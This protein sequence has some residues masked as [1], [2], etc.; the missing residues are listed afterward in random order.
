[1]KLYYS[2]TPNP[3]KPCAVAKHVNAPVEFVRVE[4]AKGEHKTPAYLAVNPNGKTPAL[5]DGDVH[6]WEAHA[7]M[8]YLALKSGSDL[9]PD[10]PV[11]QIEVMKWLN[12]DTAHFSRHAGRLWFQRFLK[13][14]IG[15]GDP[16]AAEI[17]EATGFFKQFAGILD[18]HLKGRDHI[19]GNRLTIAD[20]GV[21]TFIPLADQAELPLEPFAELRRW[22]DGM[23]AIDAWRD[24]WPSEYSTL[25]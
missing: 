20:F 12:W 8:A 1:M 15:A 23:M 18:D 24:P 21:A 22:A 9:W 19:L 5:A 10:N 16:D 6:L 17:E 2:E 14:A 4:L 7:I 13:G 3:R 25:G 11:L